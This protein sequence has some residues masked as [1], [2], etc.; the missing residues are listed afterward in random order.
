MDEMPRDP[1][2]Y[3]GA[4]D[5]W[6][7]AAKVLGKPVA[8]EFADIVLEG[9]S[10]SWLAF[11]I[12]DQGFALSRENGGNS[13]AE[14]HWLDQHEFDSALERIIDRFRQQGLEMVF[15][16]REPLQILFCWKLGDAEGLKQ[17][18]TKAIS[19]DETFLKLLQVMRSW[20]S[21]SNR[22]LYQSLHASIVGEFMDKEIAL[23]RLRNMA[24]GSSAGEYPKRAQELLSAWEQRP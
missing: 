2:V 21:S 18:V 14:L 15:A 1:Y 13:A 23:S 16:A 12:R 7:L 6:R 5:P 22:G 20:V 11:V 3:F 24:H 9:R 8:S 19:S 17:L 10:L 4:S